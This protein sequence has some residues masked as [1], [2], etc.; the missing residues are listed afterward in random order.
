MEL[1]FC[2][3][4]DIF[5]TVIANGPT[6]AT[7]RSMHSPCFSPNH[8]RPDRDIWA[9]MDHLPDS[10]R[11]CGFERAAEERIPLLPDETPLAK[12]VPL[13]WKQPYGAEI[14]R[15]QHASFCQGVLMSFA[16]KGNACR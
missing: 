9:M 11:S 5:P 6:E 10:A 1:A 13:H 7:R 2:S 12:T 14:Q 16:V 3:Y 15:L 8:R 4:S